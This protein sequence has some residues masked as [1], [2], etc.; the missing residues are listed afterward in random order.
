MSTPKNGKE[1]LTF[2]GAIN[3]SLK[4]I[5]NKQNESNWTA[6]RHERIQQIERMPCQHPLSTTLECK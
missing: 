3:I 5:H 1:I 4:K 6:K 2:L